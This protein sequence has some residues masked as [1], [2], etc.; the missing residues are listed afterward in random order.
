MHDRRNGTIGQRG[1]Q[2]TDCARPSGEGHRAAAPSEDPSV[3]LPPVELGLFMAQNLPLL[4]VVLFSVLYLPELLLQQSGIVRI[5]A[6][7]GCVDSNRLPSFRA[8]QSR[9][10]FAWT[11]CAWK[12]PPVRHRWPHEIKRIIHSPVLFHLQ[13]HEEARFFP[14]PKTFLFRS[15]ER[16]NLV[17]LLAILRQGIGEV[18]I[19]RRKAGCYSSPQAPSVAFRRYACMRMV[20]W[21]DGVHHPPPARSAYCAKSHSM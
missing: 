19:P 3:A 17:R 20:R 5:P 16:I 4:P 21:E 14:G 15:A 13:W 9:P 8:A 18:F 6:E 2:R 1:C 7:N 11:A 12:K 10:W